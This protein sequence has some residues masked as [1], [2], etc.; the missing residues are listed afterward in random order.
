MYTCIPP[1]VGSALPSEARVKRYRR[2]LVKKEKEMDDFILAGRYLLAR[3]E[4][5]RLWLSLENIRMGDMF[6]LKYFEILSCCS[7]T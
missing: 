4:K 6:D 7:L 2:N 1:P 3:S 5:I